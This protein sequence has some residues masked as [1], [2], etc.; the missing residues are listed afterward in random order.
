[1]KRQPKPTEAQAE[2]LQHIGLDP[3]KITVTSKSADGAFAFTYHGDGK[4]YRAW[5]CRGKDGQWLIQDKPPTVAKPR[6]QEK[7]EPPAPDES[8]SVAEW[9]RQGESGLPLGWAKQFAG[10]L[11]EDEGVDANAVTTT[12]PRSQIES[13]LRGRGFSNKEIE[14]VLACRETLTGKRPTATTIARE[15]GL[16][17]KT[18]T[19]IL[20]Q[21]RMRKVLEQ[22]QRGELPQPPERAESQRPDV[23]LG[24]WFDLLA[25]FSDTGWPGTSTDHDPEGLKAV[26]GSIG[27]AGIPAYREL[28]ADML[29]RAHR[30]YVPELANQVAAFIRQYPDVLLRP[31]GRPILEAMV[32]LLEA[33]RFGNAKR[34]VSGLLPT[35]ASK[36]VA[37]FAQDALTLLTE[38]EPDGKLALPEHY[39]SYLLE[40]VARR[41][42]ELQ[43]E[44]VAPKSD[45]AARIA[46]MRELHPN[47]LRRF[48]DPE[49]RGFLT[50]PPMDAACRLCAKA[51]GIHADYW[52]RVRKLIADPSETERVFEKVAAICRLLSNPSGATA[53][54]K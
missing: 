41:I 8:Q 21:P 34:R 39:Q 2:I 3:G 40:E 37:Q 31:E 5:L 51:T 26:L 4:P 46:Q 16:N 7:R 15:A 29:D 20:R 32:D 49:L 54:P 38:P 44:C 6:N 22:L 11:A 24:G 45:R 30:E 28:R 27:I 14:V 17:P 25:M 33:A 19:K 12:L 35:G 13:A 48:S 42:G 50:D 18:V 53:Q 10:S 1:M 23:G 43:R 52:Q 47:E 36:M 9:G